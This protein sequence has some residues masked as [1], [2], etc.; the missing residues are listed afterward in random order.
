M[1][2][3]YIALL[4]SL[5]AF[6]VSWMVYPWVLRYA[7]RHHIV[8]NP[9]SRKLQRIPVPVMGGMVVYAGIIAGSLALLPFLQQ[10]TLHWI[11]LG[12]TLMLVVGIWDDI[13]NLSAKV[14]FL[15]EFVLVGLFMLQT[16][17]YINDF[18]GLFGVNVLS[19]WLA[20]PL[21]LVAGVGI[22]NAVNLIDG[23]DGYSAGFGMLVCAC[24]AVLFT[25]IWR[26][27][28]VFLAFIVFASL[29]PFF[30]HNV[31]GKKTKMFFGDGGTLML[32]TLLAFY[33]FGVLWERSRCNILEQRNVGLV[34]LMMAILCIPVFDTL[35]VM[36]M[37]M[38]RGRSPFKPDKTH[39][40]HLFIDMGFS[41][42]GAAAF[43]LF[44]NLSVVLLWLLLWLL[45]ASIDVQTIVVLLM[46]LS[47]TFGFY[48]L[49]RCQQRRGPLRADGRP[50]GSR[51]WH[52][53]CHM[54][55]LSRHM[56]LGSMWKF[57]RWMVDRDANWAK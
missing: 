8:D 29:L 1:R 4:V 54:G 10:I 40:H 46:G 57:L 26:P 21:S 5:V 36:T 24:F 48:I 25:T 49:M 39:L 42:L 15:M 22:I 44:A 37:R 30:M 41:H 19:D 51:L 11:V 53:F 7:I 20:I 14:R 45:G 3:L 33:V 2:N 55:Y 12:M 52:L 23:V 32:G 13:H 9:D 43:I 18:H 27:V 17:I 35:R 31:F 50:K 38:L 34:A 28:W 6:L 16:G 56:E 47:L